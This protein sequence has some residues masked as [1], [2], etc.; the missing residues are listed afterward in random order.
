MPFQQMQ[1][2]IVVLLND[3]LEYKHR[4]HH[5]SEQTF[6]EVLFF[7]NKYEQK[8]VDRYSFRLDYTTRYIIASE[9]NKDKKISIADDFR[10]THEIPSDNPLMCKLTPC[11]RFTSS[12]C[13]T[14]SRLSD[15]FFFK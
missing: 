1:N 10:N 4:L 8:K 11:P 7:Y 6:L 15:I 14:S 9:L 2:L 5:Q 13:F 3:S 12:R